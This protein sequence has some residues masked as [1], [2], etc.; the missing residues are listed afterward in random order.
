MLRNKINKREGHL[1]RSGTLYAFR[2]SQTDSKEEWVPEELT[3]AMSQLVEKFKAENQLH[4]PDS[5]YDLSR[6]GRGKHKHD[7]DYLYEDELV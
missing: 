2:R 7:L 6:K 1:V 4:G 3:P 5:H